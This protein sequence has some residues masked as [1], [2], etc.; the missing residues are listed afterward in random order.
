MRA[1]LEYEQRESLTLI[2][3]LEM[4]I[5]DLLAAK[6]NELRKCAERRTLIRTLIASEPKLDE[7]QL[8]TKGV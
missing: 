7:I 6:E 4:Q 2:G 3:A 8:D 1:R 5:Q